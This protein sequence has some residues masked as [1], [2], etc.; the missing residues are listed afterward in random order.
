MNTSP[1]YKMILAVVCCSGI[2][3]SR[4]GL[5]RATTTGLLLAA[6][7]QAAALLSEQTACPLNRLPLAEFY[8]QEGRGQFR[9]QAT[10]QQLGWLSAQAPVQLAELADEFSRQPASPLRQQTWHDQQDTQ[11][12]WQ[13]PNG[14]LHAARLSGG[15][16]AML[17][18]LPMSANPG[19]L[20]APLTLLTAPLAGQRA[21]SRSAHPQQEFARLLLSSASG[22]AV[23]LINVQDGRIESIQT[24][25]QAGTAIAN[26]LAFDTDQNGDVDRIYFV[27]SNQQIWRLDW[28]QGDQWQPTLIARLADTAGVADAA[29]QGWAA[30]WPLPP[31]V[32]RAD[33]QSSARMSPATAQPAPAVRQ[34]ANA[35]LS[36]QRT[37]QNSG[38]GELLLL[39]TRQT[40]GYG[41]LLLKVSAVPGPVID[42]GPDTDAETDSKN[43][44]V[45]IKLAESYWFLRFQERPVSLPVVLGSVVYL[46]VSAP[47]NCLLPA[48][49]QQVLALNLFNGAPVYATRYLA[50]AQ[51]QTTA[52]KL[53]AEPAGF[54]LGTAAE[55]LLPQIRLID[56]QC[57]YCV[58]PMTA[59]A[60]SQQRWLAG[61]LAEEAF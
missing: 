52:L 36:A 20:P 42:V 53:Q 35:W 57:Q 26:P 56:P 33:V 17:W 41:L 15:Q 51:P 6:P 38:Q 58:R 23:Q 14:R 22:H 1:N 7:Q 30:H 48:D 13:L 32:N 8:W 28:Q 59:D 43:A 2:A 5:T 12:F 31:T 24:P 11:L 10:D 21:A 55:T 25:S 37:R 49:Y 18:Q 54:S 27:N 45:Q 60:L 40:Q 46:P 39:L 16:L 19:W 50:F 3:L 4:V 47:T 61:Y 44:D 34:P 9:W 29:L